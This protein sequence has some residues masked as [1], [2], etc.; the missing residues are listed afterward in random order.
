[1]M[2]YF[3]ASTLILTIGISSVGSGERRNVPAQ[4]GKKL[5][6]EIC[7]YLPEVQT[8][9][10]ESEIKE[11]SSKAF[12]ILFIFCTNAQNL[13]CRLLS[14]TC[15]IEI[16]HQIQMCIHFSINSSRF[17]PKISRTFMPFSI[18]LLYLSYFLSFLNKFLNQILEFR[19]NFS[20][21]IGYHK[22]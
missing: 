10:A 21:F 11:M 8:F 7:C 9:G 12:R 14:F 4:I 2:E 19:E 18:V 16:I 20:G 3:L 17:S 13:A 22:K 5:F 1:M 6:L 15:P